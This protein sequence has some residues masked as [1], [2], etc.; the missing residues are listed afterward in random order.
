MVLP[1]PLRLLV[2]RLTSEGK[3]GFH[4]HL[5]HSLVRPGTSQRCFQLVALHNCQLGMMTASISPEKTG[6]VK[7]WRCFQCAHWEAVQSTLPKTPPPLH[8][9]QEGWRRPQKLTLCPSQG[10]KSSEGVRSVW[11]R[12]GGVSS[13]CP[14]P[15]E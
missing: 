10:N 7:S 5:L 9:T 2:W 12:V 6:G 3:D 13:F 11:E 8:A 14:L 1:L 15:A 4:F